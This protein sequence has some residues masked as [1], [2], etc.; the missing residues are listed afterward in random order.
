MK[1]EPARLVAVGGLSGAGKSALAGAL[2]PEIGR[3]PGAVWLRSD[4]ERKSLFGVAEETHLP[5]VGLQRG[6]EP[7][8]LCAADRQGAAGVAGRRRRAVIDA[9]HAH[10]DERTA[11]AALGAQAGVRFVGLWLEAPLPTR[12]ARIA[13]RTH[14]ASDADEGVA[15][16]QYAEPLGEPGWRAVD[17]AGDLEATLAAARVAYAADA[18]I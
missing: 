12:V 16:R 17:A 15:R 5:A 6:G 9:T 8:G 2:A 10:A 3:A 13:G 18:G 4:V 7:R 11:A 14:D 1:P